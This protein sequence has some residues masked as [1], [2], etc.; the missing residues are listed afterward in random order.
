[1]LVRSDGPKGKRLVGYLTLVP[2]LQATVRELRDFLRESLPDHMVP[3]A[4]VVMDALPL[5]SNG[6]VDQRALPEP[7]VETEGSYVPPQTATEEILEGIWCEVLG[8][9]RAGSNEDFFDL[10]GHS[11]LGTQVVS[12][13]RER[14][15]VELPLRELF[16]HPTLSGLARRI[17]EIRRAAGTAA[18]PPRIEPLPRTLRDQPLE[19][20]F[21]QQRLWFLDRLE[22]GRATYNIP[23]ALH[24]EGVL[25][26]DALAAAL[27]GIVRRHEALRTTFTSVDGTP[28][29]VVN[30]PAV[31]DLPLFD[32]STLS[33]E[34]RTADTWRRIGEEARLPFSLEQGPLVRTTLLRLGPE[35]HVLLVTMHHIVS[36]GW[37]VP[38]YVREMA[39]LYEGLTT[40]KP[41][42]LPPLPVQYADF[43]H[44]Q[45]RWLQGETLEAELAHWRERLRDLPP[46]LELPADRPR[47]AV[48]DWR[49]ASRRIALR[50]RDRAGAPDHVARAGSHALHG[51]ARRLRRPPPPLQPARRASPWACPSP[52]ATGWRSSA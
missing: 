42:A 3:A 39:T 25:D 52:A 50:R 15:H 6:R 28:R 44:W 37:S 36:D 8:T 38:I 5:T 31:V 19:L 32:L 20:S 24:F 40:G 9:A 21:S 2:G 10:G 33:P 17:E 45:R 30:P 46:L 13:A 43:A 11:L 49:G 12:R 26:T 29:Q 23:L 22:P 18:A 51:D 27:N 4:L 1:M 35:E 16:D 47:P 14:F 34:E 7:A 41:Q 48:R